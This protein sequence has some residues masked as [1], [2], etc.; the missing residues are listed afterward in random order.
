MAK[1][2]KWVE[3]DLVSRLSTS[4]SPYHSCWN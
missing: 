2:L 4:A 1:H 3:I